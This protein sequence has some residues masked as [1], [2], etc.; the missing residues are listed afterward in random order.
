M[1]LN[2]KIMC[3]KKKRCKY[4][5]PNYLTFFYDETSIYPVC[6]LLMI[7]DARYSK[8]SLTF[9]PVLAEHSNKARL[10]SLARAWAC[11]N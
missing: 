8:I 3:V 7:S 11:S 9:R 1:C 5:G 10:F 6:N 4:L 2:N